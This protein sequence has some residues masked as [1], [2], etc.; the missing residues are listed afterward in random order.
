MFAKAIAFLNNATE[1]TYLGVVVAVVVASAVVSEHV[2]KHLAP[3]AAVFAA[4][5]KNSHNLLSVQ[6]PC[7]WPENK[8]KKYKYCNVHH[9]RFLISRVLIKFYS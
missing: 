2:A 9:K 7:Q 3:A 6:A 4:E 1:I 5:Q 8:S